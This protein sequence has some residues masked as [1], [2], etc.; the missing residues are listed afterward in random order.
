MGEPAAVMGDRVTGTCAGHT[1]P[2]PSG[3]PTPA[4]PLPFVAPLQSDLASSV[5]I[6]GK[7]AAVVGSRGVNTPPHAG[8]H[9]SDPHLAPAAQAG[10]VV[11]GSASVLF[12]SK[13]AAKTGSACTL[14]LGPGTLTGS[15][16]TVLIGG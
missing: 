15:A 14:C 10:T 12:E 5:L 8:L 2:A 4:P 1:V 6:R 16:V 9:P 13:P 7:P 3:N 11:G